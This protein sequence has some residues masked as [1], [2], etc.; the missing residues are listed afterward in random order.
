MKLEHA[1]AAARAGVVRAVHVDTGQQVATGQL[2]VTFEAM[3]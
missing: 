3:P 2:L 1:L